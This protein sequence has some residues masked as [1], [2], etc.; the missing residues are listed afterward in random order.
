VTGRLD[1]ETKE[2]LGIRVPERAV[3]VKE[4][5][6]GRRLALVI[7]NGGYK[8]SPLKNPVND[9]Y[10][11][12]LTLRKLG[13]EV[14]H[15]KNI[16][17]RT[18]EKTIRDFGERLRKD[19]V[20]LFYFAGHGMQVDTRNYLIPIGAEIDK[21][22]E[23]KYEAVDAGRILDEMDTAGNNLNIVILD[24]CRNNPFARSFRTGERGLARMDAPTGTIIVYSTAP[25]MVAADG[26]GRNAT[27][28]KYLLKYIT[29]PGLTVE[30]VLKKVR[31]DV[32]RETGSKQVPWESSS[33]TGDFYFAP[34][35]A[36]VIKRE[37]E[38]LER[39]RKELERLKIDRKR[40]E[41][42]RKR[43]EAEKQKLE[44]AKLTPTPRFKEIARDGRFIAYDNGTVRDTRTGLMWATRDNGRNVTWQEAE[45]YC[46]NY[47]GGGYTDWRMPTLDELKSLYDK[48]KP[49]YRQE[50]INIAGREV[51]ITKFIHLSCCCPW[52][53][54]TRGSRAA[55]FNFFNGYRFWPQQSDYISFRALPVRSGKKEK[56]EIAKLTPMPSLKEIP[57]DDRFIAYD[58]GTVKDTS[59]GLMWAARDNGRPVTW[60][61]AKEYCESSHG[62]S[63]SDW[64]MPTLDELAGLYDSSKSYQATQWPGNV[65][66]TE[67]IELTTCCPWASE[68]HDPE[69]AYFHFGYGHRYGVSKSDSRYGRA[70]PVR[71]GN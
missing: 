47:R 24:A 68:T 20:G 33:L 44:I 64:R 36:I 6:R 40:L 42:G 41:A 14:I 11:M 48:N 63:Y 18:M 37:R 71:S 52:T 65:H 59:T 49:G 51:H 60:Q 1:D 12:A 8:S 58:N 54:E 38:L 15:K 46:E 16:N 13:F 62:G 43:L 67:S 27:Y 25:G 2:R 56:L 10:D 26:V 32:I 9:A 57:R 22:T 5:I 61:E 34:K 7:G 3:R 21:E 53:S 50:C 17:Q 31:V 23:I 4:Q 30:Q 19:S 45:E 39:E 55:K 70:L 66:L 69:A 29:T 35:R 28:T